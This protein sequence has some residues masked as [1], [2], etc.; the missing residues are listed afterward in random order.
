MKWNSGPWTA[1]VVVL[2]A[3]GVCRADFM[4]WSYSWELSKGPTFTSGNSLVSFALNAD[5]SPGASTIA[6]GNLSSNSTSTATDSFNVPYDM[7]LTITDKTANT[8]GTLDFH[9]SITG[10]VGPT[11]S[12]LKNVF[13][14]PSQSLTLSGH[15][16]TVTLPGTTSIPAPNSSPLSLTG[17]VVVSLGPIPPVQKTPE[18]SAL[19][20]ATLAL[21]LL[22]ARARRRLSF[23]TAERRA[24]S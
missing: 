11:S 20:L 6:L 2:L 4:N 22:A 13:S 9:G 21:P 17:Q 12:T 5:T 3:G 10:N 15:V 8:S 16:Y 7:L 1:V 18:P 24:T 23:P 19:L 14:D